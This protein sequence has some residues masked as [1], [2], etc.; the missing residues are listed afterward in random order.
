MTENL[1]TAWNIIGIERFC[2]C[3]NFDI[4]ID[5]DTDIAIDIDF[6]DSA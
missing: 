6:V 3:F 4:D 1:S 5:S 2:F